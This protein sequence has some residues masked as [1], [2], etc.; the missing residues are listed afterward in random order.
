[1][2][3]TSLSPVAPPVDEVVVIPVP[4]PGEGPV[5]S[6]DDVG[7]APPRLVSP[8]LSAPLQD[9]PGS[10]ATSAIDVVISEK[11]EVESAK[12]ASSAGDYREAMMLSGIKA[13]RFT[14]A[15]VG[16]CPVRYRMR[17]F[18]GVTTVATGIR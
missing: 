1:M 10:G 12:L 18:V 5:L 7:V 14:P 3:V 2:P 11:G 4:K 13:W 17:I 16:G 6:R 8:R 15:S 9:E